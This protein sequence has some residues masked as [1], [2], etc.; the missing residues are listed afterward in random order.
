V[1][2]NVKLLGFGKGNND[3]IHLYGRNIELKNSFLAG[4][5]DRIC[6]T[7]LFDR[8][9]F[10]VT[11]KEELQP[12][13]EDTDVYNLRISNIVFWG[14][15][16]GADI[17]L[18]W[19]GG[20]TCRDIVIENVHSLGFTNK[21]FVGSK[22][23]GSVIVED[24]TIRNAHL[25]HHRIV[26]IEVTAAGCWGQGGG[27]VRNILFENITIDAEPG[28]VSNKMIGHSTESNVDNII[29]RNVSA[30]GVKLTHIEQTNIETNEFV[31]NIKF[32]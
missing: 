28:Q 18:T 11:K 14:Q 26:D 12:R 20:K 31:Y 19:N 10:E 5:D 6:I 32:E 2:D 17:M 22:H 16:N 8:E 7:G 13:L 15:K 9:K 21:G 29:F 25:Y 1:V 4:S 23:G 24:V 30:N 3:G 27:S